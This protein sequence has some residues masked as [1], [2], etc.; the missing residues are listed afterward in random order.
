MD[1]LDVRRLSVEQSNSSVIFG[2]RLILK[3]FRRTREGLNPEVEIPRFL[4]EQTAFD[5]V[6]R[7]LGWAEYQARDGM[8]M[9]V[10]VLEAFVPNEGDGWGWVLR[11]V[12]SSEVWSFES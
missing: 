8:S 3:A 7:L 9:P 10:G 12:S 4:G 2:D 5:H 11:T 1:R 6:P